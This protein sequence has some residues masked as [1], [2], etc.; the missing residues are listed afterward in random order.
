[1]LSL[2]LFDKVRANAYLQEVAFQQAFA[3]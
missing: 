3:G 1:V 2:L